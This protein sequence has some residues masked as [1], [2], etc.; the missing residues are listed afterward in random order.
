MK[1]CALDYVLDFHK[2][3][4]GGVQLAAQK[5]KDLGVVCLRNLAQEQTIDEL[6]RKTQELLSKP[7]VLG[8][9]GYFMKDCH[10]KISDG[11]LVGP[12]ALQTLL[13]ERIIDVCEGY[14]GESVLLQEMLIKNDLGDNELYFPMHA[15]TGVYRKIKTPGPFSVG[16]ML[17]THDTTTGAFCYAPGTHLWDVPHGA[18]PEKYPKDM[19]DKIN[20]ALCRISGR[21]GDVVLFDHRG[22]HGPEQPVTVPRTVFLGGFHSAKSHDYKVKS[23]TAVY[24]HDI[25]Q[26][27]E[28]QQRVLGLQSAGVL[29]P[30]E[31]MHTYSFHRANPRTYRLVQ[32]FLNLSF[33]LTRAKFRIKRMI[34]EGMAKY[35]GYKPQRKM[36]AQEAE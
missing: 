5:L 26:L 25:A 28:K 34:K 30:K 23:P 2:I 29:I 8:T 3:E 36:G 21:R 27:S 15:H 13:D 12:E 35:L 1:D 10:K 33:D 17:Y 20:Q 11:F 22:F 6:V 32:D 19:Q 4:E 7:A 31:K 24:A 16:I 18:D 9:S 14:L